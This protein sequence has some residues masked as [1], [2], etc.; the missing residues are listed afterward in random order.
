MTVRTLEEVAAYIDKHSNALPSQSPLEQY[1][2][3]EM[4]AITVLDS[5]FDNYP[6]GTLQDFLMDYL[7]TKRKQLS[8]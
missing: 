8:L 4:L 3:F 7:T 1:E 2:H 5:E 6:G